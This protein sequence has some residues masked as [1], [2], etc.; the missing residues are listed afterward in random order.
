MAHNNN[1]KEDPKTMSQRFF[2]FCLLVLGGVL[3]LWV[4][5]ELLAQ[6]WGWL[7]LGLIAVAVIWI[8]VRVLRARR[9]RW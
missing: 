4:A 9:D 2:T 7:L 5:L 8:L 1:N 6:F 3:L